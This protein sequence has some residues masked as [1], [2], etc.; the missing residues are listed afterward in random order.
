MESLHPGAAPGEWEAVVLG[1]GQPAPAFR[2]DGTSVTAALEPVAGGGTR[3]RLT[4]VPADGRRLELH[5]RGSAVAALQL[6]PAP[7]GSAPFN[8][9]VIYH[10]FVGTFRNG[11]R[12]NDGQVR[13]WKDPLYIGG[14]LAGVLQGLEHIQ[15]L[16]ANAVWISPVFASPTSHGYDVTNYFR[17][18]DAVGVPRDAERSLALFRELVRQAHARGIRVVL[19]IPLNH[20]SKSYDRPAGDPKKLKPEATGARQPAEKLWESWGSNMKFWAFDHAPTR[21]FLVD[22]TRHWLQDEQADG[23]RLD[24]VRGV[25]HDFWAEHY[26]AIKKAK[27]GAF[28]VGECWADEQGPAG[29][30]AEIATYFKPVPGTGPQF[31]SLLDF[32]MQQVLVDVFARGGEASGIE[33]LLQASAAAY[34]PGAW[35]TYFLDNH[36]LTRF[37]DWAGG[38]KRRLLAAFTFMSALPGPEVIFYGTE[39]GL[40]GSKVQ[41]GFTD[42]GRIPMPWNKLDQQLIASFREV[43]AARREHPAL[44]RGARW[45]LL[46][47]AGALVF[48]RADGNEVVLVGSNVSKEPRD[49]VVDARPLWGAAEPTRLVGSSAFAVDPESR[50]LRW[51]LPPYTTAMLAAQRQG[52]VPVEQGPPQ[53]ARDATRGADDLW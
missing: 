24:Y 1:I 8:D 39:T 36:D 38:D 9:W 20:A 21:K 11:D 31:D 12:G 49:I 47:D 16:G 10:V 50:Q 34:G 37:V 4:G 7:A 6:A 22:V 30:V 40:G 3:V 19:D 23:V 53:A 28:L 17:I 52:R 5:V 43:L 13:G 44:A 26:A 41:R 27:P 35:P 2:V 48:A 18:G 46:A 45:P 51:T 42:S 25:P 29:N 15:S 33:S 32:P 14:D